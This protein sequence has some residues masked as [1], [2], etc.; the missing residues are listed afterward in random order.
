[1]HLL[2]VH[3]LFV[4]LVPINQTRQLIESKRKVWI[5]ETMTQPAFRS[6]ISKSSVRKTLTILKEKQN[7]NGET[8]VGGRFEEYRV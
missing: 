2:F 4:Q 8:R 5:I 6:F 7:Q 1:M 3:I